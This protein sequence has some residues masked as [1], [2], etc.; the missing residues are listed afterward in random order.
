[1]SKRILQHPQESQTG[2]KYWRSLG[3]VADT[4][5]FRTWAEREFPQGASEL[6]GEATRR[7]FMKYMAA[8]A[9]LAGFS[10]SAC[11]REVKELVPFSRGVE[12]SVPGKPVFYATSRPH[13]RGAQ[14]LVV[15]TNDGRPTKVEGNPLHPASRGA[16]DIHSQASLLDLYDPDRSR[17]FRKSGSEVQEKDFIAAL[18][19]L[20][21]EAGDGAGIAFLTEHFTSPTFRRLQDEVA[22]KMPKAVWA[23]YEPLGTDEARK[24]Q[25]AAFG[26]GMRAVPQL[27][28]ADAVLA[29]DCD[30][31]GFDEGTLEGIRAF[32]KRRS[33]EQKMNRL[34]VVENRY[35]TTG[36]MADHRLRVKAGSIGAV[37]RQFAEIIA[38]KTGD[39]TLKSVVAKFPQGPAFSGEQ[40]KWITEAAE[41]LIAKKG[42][43]LVV[44][45]YRQPAAVQALAHAI[46]AALG[47]LGATVA[48]RKSSGR[49]RASLA[50]ISTAITAGNVKTLFILGGN[51]AFNAP[52]DLNFPKVLAGVKTVIRHGLYEDET[53]HTIGEGGKA[54]WVQW[55]VP[56]AHYLEAWGDGRAT[57]GSLL[58][59]QP[60][61][62]PL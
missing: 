53:S 60:M 37:A 36:G 5:E 10:F 25:E 56:A 47:G 52:A 24:A 8:S 34:Y 59:Q 31:L 6:K 16:T 4:P 51:P 50:E 41:D 21:K 23:E 27:D 11:R 28:K 1:M 44:V 57:D 12:W 38:G 39:E 15:A 46:N 7:D 45:G 33:P 29:L 22:K 55:H 35:T 58:S 17:H 19:A 40:G 20:L 61:I 9:A 32:A 2:P 48:G 49:P 3:Q 54:Q 30:F 26:Q 62:L 42:A 14:P 18:E 13:R 43:V